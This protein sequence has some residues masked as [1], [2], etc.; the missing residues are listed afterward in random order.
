MIVE[1][2]VFLTTLLIWVIL[3]FFVHLFQEE[4]EEDGEGFLKGLAVLYTISTFLFF[5]SGIAAIWR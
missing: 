1:Y 3:S 4:E 2:K 5:I